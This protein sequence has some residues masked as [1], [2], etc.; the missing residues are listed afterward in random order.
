MRALNDVLDRKK[1]EVLRDSVAQLSPPKQETEE[2]AYSE[3]DEYE[4]SYHASIKG[5]PLR[6]EDDDDDMLLM[7][8]A[9]V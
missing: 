7:A 5:K 4:E 6:L 8:A 2:E 9:K 1:D 3:E